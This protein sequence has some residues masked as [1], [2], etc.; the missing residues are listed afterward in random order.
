MATTAV[1]IVVKTKGQQAIE[2]LAGSVKKTDA[3]LKKLKSNLDG[4]LQASFR[5]VG[6]AGVKAGQKIKQGF[7]VAGNAAKKFGKNISGLRGQLLGLGIGAGLTKSFFAASELETAQTRV[8]VLG[9]TYTQL[10]G[11]QDIAQ[12]SAEKFRLSNVEAINSYIDLGNRLGEQGASVADLQNVFEGLNTVFA[13]NKTSAQEAAS[14]QLQLNQALGS[15]RL[16]GEEFNAINE[17]APQIISEV[18]RVL[19]VARGEVKKLASEGRVSSEVLIQALTNI[20]VSGA[21]QLEGAFDGSFGA[22]KEFN[23]AIQEFSQAVGT[24][25]LPAV[26]PLLRGATELLKAFGELPGPV[27]T[28][29]VAIT[30]VGAAAVVAAPAIALVG[31]AAVAMLAALGTAKLGA[32]AAGVGKLALAT[33]GLKVAFAALTGPIG[34]AVL[35]TTALGVAIYNTAQEQRAFEDLINNGAG[36]I[37]E[38]T[39]AK[40]KL[41]KR[42]NGVQ[43]RLRGTGG[44]MKATGRD[45]AR[46][47]KEV[48]EL[49]AQLEQ[50]E[51]TYTVRLR[52]EKEGFG[53]DADGNVESFEV[54]GVG[55]FDA[56]GVPIQT[57]Q[58]PQV[59][60]PTALQAG[61]T[62][63][64]LKGRTVGGG[65]RTRQIKEAVTPLRE[66]AGDINQQELQNTIDS[67]LLENQRALNAARAE[68]NEELERQL[69]N[70]RELIAVNE[71]L[72]AY[73]ELMARLEGVKGAFKGTAEEFAAEMEAVQLEANGALTEFYAIQETQQA[74]A[75][76]L[77]REQAKA[78]EDA[79]RPLEEQRE[80][81]EAKLNG[82]EEEV[83]LLIEARN[84]ARDVAGLDEQRVLGILQTN[85]ALE[86]QAAELERSREAME[87][88]AGNI[89]G[90]FTDA[91]GDVIK[92]T[93]TVEEAFSEMLTNI[94]NMFIDM[95]MQILQS[96]ITKQLIKLFGSLASGGG[97]FGGGM[98]TPGFAD[99]GYVTGPTRAMIGEGGEPEY[100][101]PA[102]K[103]GSAMKRYSSGMRGDAVIDGAS[104]TATGDTYVSAN[105]SGGGSVNITYSGPTLNFNG[106][107]YIPRSEA[108]KLVAEGAKM[109]EARTLGRLRGSSA[110]RRKIGL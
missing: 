58:T 43:D 102:S 91:L 93:K 65:N 99:G 109:G 60:Y 59:S 23:T 29:A 36:T 96:A 42:L 2:R 8:K 7:G 18:A 66:L 49:Q 37:D 105:G 25:L 101:I 90:E 9:Q 73:D 6:N 16:A 38:L 44:E 41:E 68:G 72:R 40:T 1:D 87:K 83:R 95:A 79:L 107:D 3:A 39:A 78:R 85:Q 22:L 84:I 53:F 110:T 64:K 30:A 70:Q 26:T 88:L 57:T 48:R 15:G 32:A 31:K 106:D 19:G 75:A 35:A 52:L 74:R 17:A 27:K 63:D 10:A 34:L 4:K 89:A 14:A 80:L 33:T 11:I 46:L 51:R 86:Q 56:N 24:E 45:A 55:R 76:T 21:S 108:P 12:Q 98:P 100:A 104:E 47:K 28:A 81:L 77:A 94:G 71:N 5:A 67:K 54:A 92:G 50:I 69:I 61:Q 62:A 20:R 82:N 97:G 103:M 13:I